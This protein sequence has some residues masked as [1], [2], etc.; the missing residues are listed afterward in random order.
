MIVQLIAIREIMGRLRCYAQQ[1]KVWATDPDG[2]AWE[3]YAITDDQ[4]E[5]HEEALD[6]A[7]SRSTSGNAQPSCPVQT[8][9]NWVS[10]VRAC[11]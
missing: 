4:V 2:N 10:K 8:I 7:T 6:H 9:R 1:D 5:T 11:C 3:I